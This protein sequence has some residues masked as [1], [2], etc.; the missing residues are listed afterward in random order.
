MSNSHYINSIN[1]DSNSDDSDYEDK[2]KN[3]TG[4]TSQKMLLNL[5]NQQRHLLKIQKKLYT[6][7]TELAREEVSSRYIKLDLSNEKIKCEKA[8]IKMVEFKTKFKTTKEKLIASHLCICIYVL[9]RL[10]NLVGIV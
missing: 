10:F 9:Y 7:Q 5:M 6:V 1:S 4:T 3:N 8:M 2:K